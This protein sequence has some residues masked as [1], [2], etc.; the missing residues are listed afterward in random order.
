MSTQKILQQ[1]QLGNRKQEIDLSGNLWTLVIE[2]NTQ[3]AGNFESGLLQSFE[4]K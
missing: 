4:P 3:T 2:K 1:S